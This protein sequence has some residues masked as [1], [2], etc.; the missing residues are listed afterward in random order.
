MVGGHLRKSLIKSSEMTSVMSK[1]AVGGCVVGFGLGLVFMTVLFERSLSN[2]GNPLMIDHTTWDW[3]SQINTWRI[4]GL[5]WV[6][7]GIAVFLI[8]YGIQERPKSSSKPSADK[9]QQPS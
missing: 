6:I 1:W 9:A 4:I 5:V 3:I 7:G 2:F 8:L